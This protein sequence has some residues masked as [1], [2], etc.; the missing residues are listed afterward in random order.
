MTSLTLWGTLNSFFGGSGLHWDRPP[1]GGGTFGLYNPIWVNTSTS[2]S[3]YAVGDSN[4][5]TIVAEGQ[6]TLGDEGQPL[7]IATTTMVFPFLGEGGSSSAYAAGVPIFSETN[8]VESAA[9][10]YWTAGSSAGHYN[11]VLQEVTDNLNIATGAPSLS[12]SGSPATLE[13]NVAL[14]PGSADWTFASNSTN[15]VLAYSEGTTVDV[16]GFS[17]TGTATTSLASFSSIGTYFMAEDASGGFHW[18]T[19]GTSGTTFTEETYNATTGV[20]GAQQTITTDL[21]G[22]NAQ[23]VHGQGV[24]CS[25]NNDGSFI[26]GMQGRNSSNQN[27]LEYDVYNSSNTLLG[28][29]QI[30]LNSTG[31]VHFDGFDLGVNGDYVIAYADATTPGGST[32]QTYMMVVGPTGN[33]L[34]GST[35]VGPLGTIFDRI[36]GLGNGLVEI[37]YRDSST[38]NEVGLIY[39]TRTTAATFTGTPGANMLAGT[40]FGTNSVDYSSLTTPGLFAIIQGG[41]G[42]V[43][44]GGANGTDRL[45][46][47]QDI[48]DNGTGRSNGD[49]FE[50][51]SAE[52]ITANSSN[53]N[54]LIELSAGVNLVYGTNFTGITEF[55]SNVGT[56]TV[57]FANDPNFAYLFGSTGNDTLTLGSGGGYLF[58]EGGTNILNGGANATNLFVGGDGGSD[59][60]NGGTG[61]ASNFYFVDGN[62]QVNGAGGFNAM[63][64]L[65]SGVTVQLGSAQYQDIQEFVGNSGNNVVTVANTDSNFVYLYGGSG[66]D[67][68]TTGSGGGYLFGEG[69]TNVLTGGGGTNVFVADGASGVDTMNGG[70]GSNIYFIDSNSTVHGAGTFNTVIELQQNATLTLGSAQLG[71]DIQEVV[72][73]GGTNTVDFSSATSSVYLYGGAGNDTLFGGS[74]NDFLYGGTGT[75]TFGFKIGWGMDTIMDWTSGTNDQIDLTALAT[76]GV[77]AITD[78]TQTI[79]N[80][81]DVITSGHTGTNSITLDGFASTLTASS[82]HFA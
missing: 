14:T 6:D 34:A 16:Q 4:T 44:K 69:G 58:G 26:L 20:F 10:V 76:Q 70:S 48:I 33:V 64:E 30:V 47:V 29:D 63:V 73:N 31:F 55:V 52:N 78:L 67:T 53:F 25:S 36:L 21:T 60:M 72:L 71:S 35:A 79:V 81:S 56:N 49:V 18:F 38:G 1:H 12:L 32:F 3:G 5:Y 24:L 77:H 19:T 17:A 39:D 46:K 59:T 57:S 62:D 7:T 54:Y 9:V 68:L 74:G 22:L 11:V 40:L 51:D 28:S 15:F 27:V 42:T 45:A 43:N 8:G 2:A 61:T 82:F 80:G 41:G 65:I 75:S 66:N 23:G 13:T 50:V 37:D